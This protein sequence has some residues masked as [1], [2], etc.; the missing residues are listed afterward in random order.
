MRVVRL[1]LLALSMS[2]C[3]SILGNDYEVDSFDASVGSSGSTAGAGAA[4]GGASNT[5]GSPGSG[6]SSGA[7]G[8]AGAGGASGTLVDA[9]SDS[10]TP[11]ADTKSDRPLE[12]TP[13]AADG[14]SIDAYDAGIVIDVAP[15]APSCNPLNGS[16]GDGGALTCD[17]GFS[18]C[19]GSA[20]DGCECRTSVC[21]GSSCQSQHVTCMLNGVPASPCADGT[22]QYF[23]DCVALGTF[24]NAQATKACAAVTGD[25]SACSAGVCPGMHQVICGLN[26]SGNCICWEYAGPAVGRVLNS[27]SA[28][29][30]C[31][32][33]MSPTWN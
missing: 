11:D 10:A 22:G 28:S 7:G 25:M 5:G 13:D 1:V 24:N 32:F 12:A 16:C 21:C 2:G 9:S 14:A 17:P 3:A 26:G 8:S 27:G 29:C 30:L 6:G 31:P 33:A 15:E 20:S 18:S 23:Y 19:N 4:G